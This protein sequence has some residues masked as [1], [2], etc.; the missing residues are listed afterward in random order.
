VLV[1]GSTVACLAALAPARLPFTH[2]CGCPPAAAIGCRATP[3]FLD[4][5]GQAAAEA[6]QL[7]PSSGGSSADVAPGGDSIVG[8]I[9]G[10]SGSSSGGGALPAGAASLYEQR[11]WLKCLRCVGRQPASQQ[12][13][14]SSQAFCAFNACPAA[15]LLRVR[16]RPLLHFQALDSIVIDPALP[17]STLPA[18]RWALGMLSWQRCHAACGPTWRSWRSEP[19]VV[20]HEG[21]GDP[22]RSSATYSLSYS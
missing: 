22:S 17:F 21:P 15:L 10:G 1:E 4:L 13:A 12:P 14:A 3:A 16:V 9:M 20:E 11:M 6:S 8:R 2:P 7:E 18:G 5:F 19:C